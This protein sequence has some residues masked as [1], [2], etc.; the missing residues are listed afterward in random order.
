VPDVLTFAHT[1]ANH[2]KFNSS[3]S[4][5]ERRPHEDP[6]S[7]YAG[8]RPTLYDESDHV[9]VLE[10]DDSMVRKKRLPSDS[11]VTLRIRLTVPLTLSMS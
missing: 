4:T 3:T 8:A 7:D 11:Q 2:L 5:Q 10:M 9:L 1:P 6:Y